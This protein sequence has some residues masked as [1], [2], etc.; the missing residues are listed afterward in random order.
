MK[1]FLARLPTGLYGLAFIAHVACASADSWPAF[2][3]PHLNGLA[4]NAKPPVHFGPEQNML[5]KTD[6]PPGHSSPVT[7]DDALFLTGSRDKQLITLCLDR[8]T[9]KVRWENI[10]PVD[11]LE[12]AH[13]VN[14]GAT[15]TPVTDG[16]SLFVY[17][18][19]FGLLAYDLSGRELWRKPLPVPIT[20]RNQGSGTSPMLADGKLIIYVQQEADSHLL[21]LNPVDG[22]ELWKTPM[23]FL[24]NAYSTPITWTEAGKPL[25]GVAGGAQFTAYNLADGKPVWWVTNLGHEACSTPIAAGNRLII[26]TAGVQGEAANITVPPGFDEAVKLYSRNGEPLVS[27]DAIPNDLLFT[28]RKTS[29][30]AG[31]MRL[32]TMFTFVTTVKDGDKFDRAAWEKLRE[33]LA[34]FASGALTQAVVVCARTGGKQDVTGSSVMWRETKGVP[35]VPS[36][37]VWQN[38]LYLIRSGSVLAC[39]DLESGNVIYEERIG[40]PSGYYS[41]PVAAN[42][43]LYFASDRGTITVVKAGDSPEVIAQNK[44][45]SPIFASPAIV[46]NA[47]YVRT[48]RQLWAFEE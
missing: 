40:S 36:P 34:S 9:G 15:S 31:N 2:R 42:G 43:L 14:S 38:R 26:S 5:W 17:F 35:E 6:A 20:F 23:P 32:K 4:N 24:S 19:S 29:D 10:V 13:K 16:K 11:A 37:L 7:W 21:A 27:Y 46:G 18:S 47:L 45:G 3:G 25:V 30:G 8:R 39:R 48:A 22:R 28:D 33:A 1:P 12:K 41:S 44:L